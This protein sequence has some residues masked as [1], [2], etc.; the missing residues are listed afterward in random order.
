M[1]ILIV[2]DFCEW[3]M[4]RAAVD[5]ATTLYLGLSL[6]DWHDIVSCVTTVQILLNFIKFIT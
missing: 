2:F 6:T 1:L 5:K 4:D 3:D